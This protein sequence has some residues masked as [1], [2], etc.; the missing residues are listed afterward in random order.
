MNKIFLKLNGAQGAPKAAGNTP[1]ISAKQ[2]FGI[3]GGKQYCQP[4]MF[5]SYAK[6]L[7]ENEIEQ[8]EQFIDCM[9]DGLRTIGTVTT[10]RD[11]GGRQYSYLNFVKIN[12]T[13]GIKVILEAGMKQLISD[14]Q[15]GKIAIDFTLEQ[16]VEEA[17]NS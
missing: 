7:R 3:E 9:N 8:L 13:V 12:A 2:F 16:L 1:V 4:G 10:R 14:Y 15:D 11:K 5:I 6:S 17:L